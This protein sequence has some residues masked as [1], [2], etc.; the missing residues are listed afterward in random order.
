MSRGFMDGYKTYSGPRGDAGSWRQAFS[1]R[2]GIAEARERVGR[3]TP[4]SILGLHVGATWD[5]VR[6]TYRKMAMECHPDRAKQN[7]MPAEMA[8]E[9]FKRVQ[10]AYTV[11]EE[12][13]GR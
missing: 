6:R 3:D 9:K 10:A 7:D 5:E 12:R 11:L 1:D 2:M 13:F 4:E 8:T